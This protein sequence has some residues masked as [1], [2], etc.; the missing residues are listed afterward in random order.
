MRAADDNNS[1]RCHYKCDYCKR[2]LT[3]NDSYA[4]S[5]PILTKCG[6][7]VS[8]LGVINCAEVHLYRTNGFWVAGPRKVCVFINLRPLYTAPPSSAV[9]C[10]RPTTGVKQLPLNRIIAMAKK[11]NLILSPATQVVE[12]RGFFGCCNCRHI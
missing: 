6:F 4:P 8:F 3:C 5:N 10:Y 9:K 1:T 2:Y 7:W 12:L 11:I